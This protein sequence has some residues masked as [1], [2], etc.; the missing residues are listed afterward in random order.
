VNNHPDRKHVTLNT[1]QSSGYANREL[2]IVEEVGVLSMV[3]FHNETSQLALPR[4]L[5]QVR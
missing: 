5:K 1:W 2:E 4:F 3:E